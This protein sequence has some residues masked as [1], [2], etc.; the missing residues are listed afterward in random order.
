MGQPAASMGDQIVGTCPLHLMPNPATGLPQ[1]GT[2]LPFIAPITIGCAPNVMINGAPAAVVG[3]TGLNT[4]PHV[5]L[6]PLDPFFIPTAQIG[7][8]TMG[9]TKVLIGGRPAVRMGDPATCCGQP[10]G[11][12][13]VKKPT[14]VIS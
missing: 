4:P 8:L 6:H 3:A 7:V 11:T 1:P 9:S 10:V 5:G 2:P 13:V 12:V 14:V